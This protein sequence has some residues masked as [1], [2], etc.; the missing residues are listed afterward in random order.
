MLGAF[1]RDIRR[2]NVPGMVESCVGAMGVI[3]DIA[4]E[5]ERASV[6]L[7]AGVMNRAPVSFP[8]YLMHVRR[9]REHLDQETA[10]RC[11]AKGHAM[12]RDEAIAFALRQQ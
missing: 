10:R 6:L 7:G 11:R 5:Y 1:L 12:S 8:A 3:A 9:V 4:G 2:T